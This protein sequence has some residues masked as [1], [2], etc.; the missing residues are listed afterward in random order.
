MMLTPHLAFISTDP[1]NDIFDFIC[2]RSGRVRVV[3]S[4]LPSV[5]I[6]TRSL[7]MRKHLWH[8]MLWN[9]VGK[10]HVGEYLTPKLRYFLTYIGHF[11]VP[12]CTKT[13]PLFT[14]LP[15]CA[16]CLEKCY[17]HGE[18]PLLYQFSHSNKSQSL[19]HFSSCNISI[20]R[21]AL[22]LY[23]VH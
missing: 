23:F 8:A 2:I 5:H 9:R 10:H 12:N 7:W 21:K 1:L 11:Y 6:W 17:F 4:V 19:S 18:P 3:C 20:C 14:L 22:M 16:K 13:N 15:H